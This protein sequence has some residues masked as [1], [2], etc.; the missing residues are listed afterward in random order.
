[1]TIDKLLCFLESY[2]NKRPAANKAHLE[3]LITKEFDLTKQRSV[4]TGSDFSI[5]FST[6][7][8]G[9]FSNVVL[10]LSA[11]RK[12]DDKPFI[13]CVVKPDSLEFL[14]SNSTFLKKIS[15][16]S[17][18]FRIDNIRGSFLGHDIIRDYDGIK[19][20]PENF[21]KL[22]SI[23]AK[24]KW[25]DNI[26][27]LVEATNNIVAQGEIFYPSAIE[28]RNI[29]A[30]PC[31]AGSIL[32]QSNYI[33][34]KKELVKVIL[35]K[36][37]D[38]LEIAKIDNVNLR[39]NAIEQIITGEGNAHS[40]ED[41]TKILP[42]NIN[43]KVEIKSTLLGRSSNPKAYNVDKM[44]KIISRGNAICVFCF[45][46]VNLP[47]EEILVKVV[48][49]FDKTVLE[50]T[51][52]QFH[53]AGRNSRGVTQLTGETILPVFEPSFEEFIDIKKA[54]LFLTKLLRRNKTCRLPHS[55][56]RE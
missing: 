16:S 12:Y 41:M 31:L 49:I 11:L 56:V 15:H 53:W 43:L 23:H 1:M 26:H 25:D 39:G 3:S 47:E 42:D 6:A 45:I 10:S 48:S 32:A 2:K 50:A 36:R 33:A 35:K 14:L 55:K 18:Q 19:N 9:T 22:F 20:S 24:Q 21:E 38:I 4:W 13:I 28:L 51:G 44:L 29:I 54:Q 17:H 27:R 37:R 52:L 46:G 40:F 30:A 8:E 7:N 5:R 34:V